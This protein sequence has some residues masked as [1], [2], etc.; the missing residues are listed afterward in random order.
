MKKSSVRPA[1]SL[2]IGMEKPPQGIKDGSASHA[3]Q[4]SSE[5]GGMSMFV[6]FAIIS[7]NGLPE[8]SP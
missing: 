4:Q 3:G 7:C 2:C 1:E 8:L 6:T 5:K